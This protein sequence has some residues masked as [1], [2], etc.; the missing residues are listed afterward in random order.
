MLKSLYR[1]FPENGKVRLVT[2]IYAI[3]YFI[4][5]LYVFM[6]QI[7]LLCCNKNFLLTVC[8][9]FRDSLTVVDRFA[10]VEIMSNVKGRRQCHSSFRVP[11]SFLGYYHLFIGLIKLGAYMTTLC[12]KKNCTLFIFPITLSILGQFG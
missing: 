9:I 10:V 11:L 6:L 5:V 1:D 2:R 8:R 12:F 4:C 3:I 7:R